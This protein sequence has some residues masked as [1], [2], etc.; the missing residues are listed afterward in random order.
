LLES[1]TNAK[2]MGKQI[3][4]FGDESVTAEEI[5]RYS[6]MFIDI[7]RFDKEQLNKF[8]HVLEIKK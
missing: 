7:G 2:S 6:N 5:K 8:T 3:I 1:I 4:V